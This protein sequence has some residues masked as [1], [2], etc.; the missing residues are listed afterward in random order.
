MAQLACWRWPWTLGLL[1]C[2]RVSLARRSSQQGRYKSQRTIPP[3]GRLSARR[4]G[5]RQEYCRPLALGTILRDS[6]WA[7]GTRLGPS[8]APACIWNFRPEL[9]RTI[10][11]A[12]A[13]VGRLGDEFRSS[14]PGQHPMDA[15]H[16]RTHTQVLR[17]PYPRKTI[18]PDLDAIS[19]GPLALD[20][21]RVHSAGVWA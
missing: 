8:A 5:Q 21:D 13:Y 6:F 16:R 18:A 15:G 9:L 17:T 20:R 12:L 1:L 4:L 7:P 2:G 14:M 3:K 10:G 11:V 19:L